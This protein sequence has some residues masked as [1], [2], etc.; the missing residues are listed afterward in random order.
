MSIKKHVALAL[1]MESAFQT[2]RENINE[3]GKCSLVTKLKTNLIVVNQRQNL[4][5]ILASE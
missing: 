1:K 4:V 2:E 3:L 5:N